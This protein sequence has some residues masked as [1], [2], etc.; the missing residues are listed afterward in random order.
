MILALKH[1]PGHPRKLNVAAN[2]GG[3]EAEAAVKVPHRAGKEPV[4]EPTMQ[5]RSRGRPPR[6]GGKIP[7]FCGLSGSESEPDKFFGGKEV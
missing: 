2:V 1:R 7:K 6:A 3:T 4:E 5:K